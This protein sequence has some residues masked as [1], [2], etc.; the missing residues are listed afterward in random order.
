MAGTI[1][2]FDAKGT[3]AGSFAFAEAFLPE[4]PHVHLMHL[5]VI[6]QL[7][8]KRAGTASTLTRSEVS[9][10]GK[11]PW[12]QKGTGNAR[13]G[14]IRSPLWRHGGVIFG[15][16]PRKFSLN[17]SVK[18][19]RLALRSALLAKIADTIA[20]SSFGI[21]APSTKS[22]VAFLGKLQV[23]GKV[24]LLVKSADQ[25]L[26]L[27]ARNLKDVKLVLASNL[28]VK[29]LLAADRVVA[30]EEALRHIEE[31]FKA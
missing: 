14:S 2:I 16:K 19:R 28:S 30:T 29:D 4:A 1:Q 18:S 10:G 6:R 12:K 13:A 17:L 9:G 7:R 25:A 24:L 20:V 11:K 31:V 3:K 8:H 5:H 27:S 15:P 21:E 23:Q 26:S 22:L